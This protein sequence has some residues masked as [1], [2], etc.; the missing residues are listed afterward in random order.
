MFVSKLLRDIPDVQ[1]LN[2]K[3]DDMYGLWRF[4]KFQR[5]YNI[6][7]RLVEDLQVKTNIGRCNDFSETSNVISNV[8]R[9]LA[10]LSF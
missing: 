2:K 1:K 9:F 7:I 8:S 4:C 5:G 10:F 6:G 3:L